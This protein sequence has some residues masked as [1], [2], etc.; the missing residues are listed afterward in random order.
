MN[1][2]TKTPT[3]SASPFRV[4]LNGLHPSIVLAIQAVGVDS[5]PNSSQETQHP[6][7]SGASKNRG[8][9][10][11]SDQARPPG[12]WKNNKL[13]GD[14]IRDLFGMVETWPF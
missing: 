14:S 3:F 5:R 6:R 7:A 11:S 4:S 2:P 8:G 9:V 10:G 13:P 12:C 1:L